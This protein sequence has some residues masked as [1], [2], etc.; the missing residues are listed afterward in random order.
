MRLPDRPNNDYLTLHAVE[1]AAIPLSVLVTVVVLLV[2]G[3]AMT[4][5]RSL[6]E[7]TPASPLAPVVAGVAALL[8][9]GTAGGV[10]LGYHRFFEQTDKGLNVPFLVALPLVGLA[11]PVAW[12]IDS[13]TVELPLSLF[14]LAVVSAHLLAF[15]TIAMSSHRDE[16]RRAGFVAGIAAG[17]PILLALV[18]IITDWLPGGAASAA[19]REFVGVVRWTELPLHR[20]V[21]V[22]APLLVTLLYAGYRVVSDDDEDSIELSLPD[23]SRGSRLQSLPLLSSLSGLTGDSSSASDDAGSSSNGSRWQ[24][25]SESKSRSTASRSDGGKRKRSGPG[26]SRPK[27]RPSPHRSGSKSSRSRSASSGGSSSG[28]SSASDSSGS[29]S[30]SSSSGNSNSSRSSGSTSSRSSSGSSSTGRSDSTGSGSSS[31][32]GASTSSGSAASSQQ[33]GEE[34][35]SDTRIFTDDF[36]E[37]K[38]GAGTVDTCPDCNKEI[39]SDGVY[40]FCPFCGETL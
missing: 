2:A 27:R 20:P 22:G 8:L 28:R 11:A 5:M 18:T 1:L 14:V 31:A 39:P 6:G 40:E 29:S 17:I 33:S 38:S 19:G 3:G 13:G 24:R 23:T 9:A 26:T 21:L 10:V 4:F 34:T 37:Y 25:K 36:G 12:A 15:R 32:Q 30:S 7:G 16:R 35:G